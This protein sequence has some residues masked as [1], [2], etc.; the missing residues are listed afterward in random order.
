MQEPY[1]FLDFKIQREKGI[2]MTFDSIDQEQA[3]K[4]KFKKKYR[5]FHDFE[6]KVVDQYVDH[7]ANKAVRKLGYRRANWLPLV[8]VLITIMCIL[9]VFAC[10]ARPD[11]LTGIVCVLAIFYLSD[12]EDINRD[13]FRLL[14]LL[15]LFSIIYDFIWLFFIQ[16]MVEEGEKTEKGLERSVKAF[17]V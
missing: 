1:G 10:V 12:N 3:E 15:Q 2:G 16:N 7:Y 17:S 9:N 8:Q 4:V 11:F 5:K 6:K 14:P 13:K